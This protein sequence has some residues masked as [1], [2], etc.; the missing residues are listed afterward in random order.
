MLARVA[1]PFG[2]QQ[3]Y[4]GDSKPDRKSNEITTKYGI[5]ESA[6]GKI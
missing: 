5:G 3:N 1:I 2:K 4:N 6:T